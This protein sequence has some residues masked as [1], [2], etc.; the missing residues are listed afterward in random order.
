MNPSH[1]FPILKARAGEMDALGRLPHGH[2]GFVTPILEVSQPGFKRVKAKEGT[3]MEA[4]RRSLTEHVDTVIANVLEHLREGPR[5]YLDGHHLNQEGTMPDGT[6][7]LAY[8][9][10]RLAGEGL[11]AGIV[12]R[13]HARSLEV[14]ALSDLIEQ[15]QCEVCLRLGDSDFEPSEVQATAAGTVEALGL[16]ERE[17]ELLLD[18][19]AASGE[20]V[21]SM[22]ITAE[23]I[24]GA[25]ARGAWKSVIA[26][27][28][29]YERW[30][31]GVGIGEPLALP[32]YE[33]RVFEAANRG[34]RGRRVQYGDFGVSGYE[35]VPPSDFARAGV[36]L[37]YTIAECYLLYFAGQLKEVGGEGFR[38]IAK[39]VVRHPEF[40]P[41]L[42]WGDIFIEDCA[43]GGDT[44]GTAKWAAVGTS[45]HIGFLLSELG[46]L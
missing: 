11:R 36:K 1:Y 30:P 43:A 18:F 29:A 41:K 12:V 15:R 5:L 22:Q 3:G 45:H 38:S 28:T 35:M 33:R 24:T 34:G 37:R 4:V 21:R 46:L 9:V 20:R 19:G 40:T 10:R 14:A 7:P 23:T 17:V 13:N 6:P 32:R 42:T 25:V 16:R 44:G 2:M 27:S 8:I 26:A 39:R 31:A